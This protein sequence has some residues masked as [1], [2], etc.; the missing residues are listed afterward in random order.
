M[1]VVV[2]L[3]LFLYYYHSRSSSSS[4]SSSSSIS[5]L[6]TEA[7]YTQVRSPDVPSRQGVKEKKIKVTALLFQPLD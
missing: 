1:V 4:N 5:S 2:T 6:V 3:L 7:S